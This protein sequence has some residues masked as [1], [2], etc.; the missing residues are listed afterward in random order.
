[1]INK[2]V[3]IIAKKH[4]NVYNEHKHQKKNTNRMH[5]IIIKNGTL[6]DGSG[7]PMFLADL[8]ISENKIKTI[9]N[10]QNEKADFVIDARDKYV[11]PGFIDVNNHSDTYWRIFLNPDLESL[12]YQG[13]T[14]IIGGNCGS[15]LAPLVDQNIIQTIQKW[16]D[17]RIV[18][19][20]WLRMGEFLDEVEKKNLSVNF[21]TLVGHGT[22][23]RGLIRDEVRGLTPEELQQAKK[24]LKESLKEGAIGL[25]TGLVYTHAKIASEKEIMELARIVKDN[26][27]VY[28]T[29]IRGEA[30]E[31][32]EA[33]EE[34]I[35]IARETGV[36][37]QIS[38][39][40]AMC[41]K[42][43]PLM[44]EAI[45]L[46]ETARADQLDVN[47]D[48]YPYTVTGSVLYIL[49]PDWVVEG[50]K[51]IMIQRLKNPVIRARVVQEMR[52][53]GF[54]YSK[55]IIAISPFNKTLVR[56]RIVDIA[57]A[58]EKSIEEVIV[59]ILIAS[60][61]RVITMMEVLGE[62]NVSKAIRNPFSIISSNGAG[63]SLSH[64]K[65][66]ELVHPRNFGSFPRALSYYVYE[67]R[68]LSW[69]EAVRKMTGLPAEKFGI[70]KR[71]TLEEG[72]FADIAI[73]NPETVID[74]ATLENPYRYSKGVSWLIVNG[75]IVLNEGVYNGTRSG[76]VLRRKSG[77]F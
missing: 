77:W 65:S 72:N 34:A 31:L 54:D 32:L 14:T 13:I 56:R 21:A 5:D 53:D 75:K 36:K 64:K 69:E 22:L 62:K 41:E 52:T 70:Q 38:H 68:I 58:Q 35:N 60:E 10:L 4:K 11:T 37:V 3:H 6:V 71:G 2:I 67:R 19:L 43:W 25:S 51:K 28:T 74:L 30:H 8:G 33:V 26:N 18:N 23:R 24:M 63:Y 1:M 76:E 7:K 46:I 17:I 47:F 20:N 29:H 45:N 48:V 44:D 27:G 12:L 55:I 40:K 16:V 61:G 9:G 42:N 50:G 39:L 49:L 57:A 66:G 73:I 59:D 15:S